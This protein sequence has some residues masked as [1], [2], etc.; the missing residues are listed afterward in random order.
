MRGILLP[1]TL[2]LATVAAVAAIAATSPQLERL[3]AAETELSADQS[4][5]EHQ[6][7]R[8]LSVLE[9]LKRDPPPALLVSPRDGTCSVRG[10]GE[11]LGRHRDFK[12]SRGI[13]SRVG[14]PG[15]N[16][17]RDRTIR[18][19]G[20][21]CRMGRQWSTIDIGSLSRGPGAGLTCRSGPLVE[22]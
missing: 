16:V 1:G 15:E 3:N 17:G 5:N 11:R 13:P 6:L 14:W 4:K 18:R 8:L 2:G 12:T 21:T 22:S 19:G 20:A 9:Q 10:P 7:A